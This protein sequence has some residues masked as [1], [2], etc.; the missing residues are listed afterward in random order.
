MELIVV[1]C[2]EPLGWLIVNFYYL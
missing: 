2:I 1:E